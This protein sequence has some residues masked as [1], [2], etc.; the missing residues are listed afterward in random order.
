MEDNPQETSA[1]M[2]LRN[3]FNEAPKASEHVRISLESEAN[4]HCIQ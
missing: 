3:L 1:E 2:L 4:I